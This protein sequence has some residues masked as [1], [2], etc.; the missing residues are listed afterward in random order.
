MDKRPA[1]S[2]MTPQD[3][4][5]PLTD[6]LIRSGPLSGPKEWIEL[7]DRAVDSHA[8]LER[9][10]AAAQALADERNMISCILMSES[11]S[12]GVLD[13]AFGCHDAHSFWSTIREHY[14]ALKDDEKID[15]PQDGERNG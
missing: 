4:P 9:S 5:T 6:A 1:E 10:L 13:A 8:E 14:E 12:A 3:T 15:A 2:G 7:W 11:N